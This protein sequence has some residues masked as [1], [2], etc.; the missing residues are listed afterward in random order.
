MITNQKILIKKTKAP[1]ATKR[2]SH[3]T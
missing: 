2:G 3:A 1:H